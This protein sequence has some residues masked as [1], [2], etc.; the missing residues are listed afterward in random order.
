M[1]TSWCMQASLITMRERIQQTWHL[2][3]SFSISFIILRESSLN[4]SCNSTIHNNQD[5]AYLPVKPYL[6]EQ[7]KYTWPTHDHTS[8]PWT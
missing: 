4:P 2:E 6:K 7:D 3:F 5:T 8:I 1:E